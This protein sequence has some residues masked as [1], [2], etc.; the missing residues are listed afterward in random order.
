MDKHIEELE[1]IF[2]KANERFI[3]KNTTLFETQVPEKTLCGALMTELYE[4]LKD[5]K[6]FDYF[7]D[8]EYNRNI[9]GRLKTMKKTIRGPEEQIITIN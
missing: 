1:G 2:E 9:G 6:Y 3:R 7:V 5:T 4:V 8:V